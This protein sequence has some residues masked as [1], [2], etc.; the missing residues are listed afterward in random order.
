MAERKGAVA[1]A[2]TVP[3]ERGK[4]SAGAVVSL[5][6]GWDNDDGTGRPPNSGTLTGALR[7]GATASM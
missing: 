3:G 4:G 1:G 2:E 7:A 5:G 6:D